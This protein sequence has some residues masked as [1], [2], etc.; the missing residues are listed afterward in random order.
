MNALRMLDYGHGYH[1]IIGWEPWSYLFNAAVLPNKCHFVFTSGIFYSY[2]FGIHHHLACYSTPQG[3][4]PAHISKNVYALK[5]LTKRV[6]LRT[7][8]YLM[9]TSPIPRPP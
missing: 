4:V 1:M 8:S 2:S 7:Y 5:E 6:V 9:I 3:T